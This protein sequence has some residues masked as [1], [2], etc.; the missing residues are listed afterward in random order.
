MI[1]QFSIHKTQL[2]FCAHMFLNN[3]KQLYP[4]LQV[5]RCVLNFVERDKVSS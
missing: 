2:T 5:I 3:N 1:L 4:G